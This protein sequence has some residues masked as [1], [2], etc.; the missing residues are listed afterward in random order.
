[1][2]TDLT[3]PRPGLVDPQSCPLCAGLR[4]VLGAAVLLG[5]PQAAGNIVRAAQK[6]MIHGHPD[7]RRTRRAAPAQTS[8]RAAER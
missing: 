1:V 2:I 3:T 6:H 4:E 5:D 7:D 8:G